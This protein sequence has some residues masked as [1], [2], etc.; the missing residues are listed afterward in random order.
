MS[1]SEIPIAAIERNRAWIEEVTNALKE[2]GDLDFSRS[3]MKCAGKR[4]AG[5]LMEKIIKHHGR[6]P[7]S[8]DEM[9]EAINKRRKE[10]L[11]VSNL[12]KREENKAFF[13]IGYLW[14]RYGRVWFGGTQSD[15]L[16]VFGRCL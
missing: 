10:V 2:K 12:W 16:S 15:V 1:K 6:T 11:K 4:C 7:Q 8:I 9:I 3:T 5:Q 14:L 13:K